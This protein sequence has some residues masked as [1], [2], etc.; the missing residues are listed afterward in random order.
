MAPCW[1]EPPLRPE[2]DEGN[3]DEDEDED[4]EEVVEDEDDEEEEEPIDLSWCIT[5]VA[6]SKQKTW[7][8]VGC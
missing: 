2:D 8:W 3:F 5:E 6:W 7:C 1:L 4:E